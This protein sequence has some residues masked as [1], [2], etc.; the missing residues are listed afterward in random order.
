MC[1]SSVYQTCTR[2]Q[3]FPAIPGS[4]Y[5]EL[6]VIKFATGSWQS[7]N[8]TASP[9]YD[10][11]T[12]YQLFGD[13]VKLLG[14]HTLKVGFDGRQYR[15]RIRTLDNGGSPSGE[16]TF[17]SNWMTSGTSGSGAA[18]RRRDGIDAPGH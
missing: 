4:P 12:N 16:Y 14:K 13:V 2:F 17:G 5:S 1:R 10:P 8:N 7:F 18:F 11:T 3:R 9:S 15:M 6:P